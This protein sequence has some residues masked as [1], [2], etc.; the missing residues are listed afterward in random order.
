CVMIFTP[1]LPG[2]PLSRLISRINGFVQREAFESVRSANKI[3][4]G[5]KTTAHSLS[6]TR[7][8]EDHFL[9][10]GRSRSPGG[11]PPHFGA[12][13]ATRFS[14]SAGQRRR[15]RSEERRVGK[16]GRERGGRE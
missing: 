6:R 5:K 13:L 8:G 4:H 14:E 3:R 1:V 16:E 12:R 10:Q 9:L 2:A 7:F 11:S 15:N